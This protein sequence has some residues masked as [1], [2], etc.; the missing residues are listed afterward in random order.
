MANLISS[1]APHIHTKNDSRRIML[2]VIIALIP[3]AVAAVIL[4][5]VKAALLIVTCVL[6]AVVCELVYSLAAK[7]GMTVKDLSSVVTGLL[8]A[9]N[10]STNVELW[11]AAIG[12]AFAIIIVKCLF[13]GLG[14][15]IVNP[16]IGG[17]VFMI[18][19]F[20]SV[21]G[22]A[23]PTVNGVDA[24][25][26][27]TPLDLIKQGGTLPTIGQMLL[28]VHGCAIGETCIIALVIGGIYLAVRDVIRWYVPATFIATVFVLTLIFSGSFS[29]AVYAI[30]SGGLFLGAIF[31]ATDYVTTPITN[32]GKVVFALGCGIITFIIRQFL[33]YPEGVSFSIIVMNLLVP[34]IEKVTKN[35]VFGGDKK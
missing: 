29:I 10:L 17:R 21:A 24:L 11:Q 32:K 7:R 15:N 19:V 31:M 23:M 9:L 33:N 2:D 35:K 34:F 4:F 18:L 27:A 13:G 20:A 12:T 22:G 8:L 25:T 30:L 6:T 3:A 26:S 5:G 1:A 28:G 16:A 14:K